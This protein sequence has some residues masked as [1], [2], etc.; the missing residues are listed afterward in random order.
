MNKQEIY[1]PNTQSYMEYFK[2]DMNETPTKTQKIKKTQPR[3]QNKAV[4]ISCARKLN[5]KTDMPEKN[6]SL[7]SIPAKKKDDTKRK[8]IISNVKDRLF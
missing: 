7:T 1:I 4:K 8:I 3:I 6:S 5:F 2:T